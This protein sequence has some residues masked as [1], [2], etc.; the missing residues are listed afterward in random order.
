ME[1]YGRKP[2]ANDEKALRWVKSHEE[3]DNDS[4]VIAYDPW[5]GF[6][7]E[8]EIGDTDDDTVKHLGRRSLALFNTPVWAKEWGLQTS[9][10]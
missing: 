4:T 9:L 3:F 6:F 10:K 7:I 1:T 5:A 2:G 8:V